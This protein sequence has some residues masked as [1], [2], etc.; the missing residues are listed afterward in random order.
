MGITA[1]G[2]TALAIGASGALSA[3]ASLYGSSQA[4]GANKDAAN[5]QQQQMDARN[6][7]ILPY[8]G[9]SWNSLQGMQQVANA[10]PNAGGPDY[11]GQAYQNLPGQMT[12]AQL[13]QTPGYQFDLAQGLKATQSSA[14]A[15]GLGV[16]GAALKGAGTYATGLAN[17]T[18]LDQFNVGQ[19]RFQDYLNLNTGQ[20]GNITNQFNRLNTIAGLGENAIVGTG[21]SNASLANQA[22]QYINAAGVN[23][24]TGST[25]ASNA[26]TSGLN[27][28]LSYNQ[29]QQNVGTKGYE[30]G[31]TYKN[32]QNPW[33][34]V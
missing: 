10:G 16:S 3:G 23:Q 22:G 34:D 14:A 4:A 24:G 6:A 33:T 7:L 9:P 20:Q 31:G 2:A 21:A 1:A 26:L 29:Y 28:Y 19:Q 30:L 18:Y 25:N 17:K 5:V 12:Q 11:V 15:R 13:E 32:E 27:N 8:L